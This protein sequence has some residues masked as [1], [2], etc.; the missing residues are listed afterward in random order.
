M[1]MCSVLEVKSLKELCFSTIMQ[2]LLHRRELKPDH[3]RDRLP[4]YV[5]TTV[6][7]CLA[8]GLE[9]LTRPRLLPAMGTEELA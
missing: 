1:S 4:D 7:H 3:L 8:V 9:E 5:P 6:K 2:A